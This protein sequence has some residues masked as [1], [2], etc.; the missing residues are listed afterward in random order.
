MTYRARNL[1]AA[2]GLAVLAALLVGFYVTNYKRSV[3]H[4]QQHVSVWVASKDIPEGTSG[5]DVISGGYL[6]QE[7]VLRQSVVPGAISSDTQIERLVA[8][9]P[10]YAGEQVSLTRFSDVAV[11]GIRGVLR[12]PLRAVQVSGDN[13]QTL[14]GTLRTGDHIDIVANVKVGDSS[15][16]TSIS[17][18]V[19]R[20]L[21]VLR[22]AGDVSQGVH[23]SSPSQ[24]GASVL[25]AVTDTQVQKL[26][27]V[28]KNDDWTFELRPV[29]KATDSPETVETQNTIV[30]DGLSSRQLRIAHGG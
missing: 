27:Y 3:Q 11:Q 30:D 10:T 22:A 14:A 12:G 24:G 25:L 6:R 15:N 28:I 29:V 8:A 5:T 18:I 13:D 20:N 9:Q 16:G 7:Q 26:F 19:L 1:F 17:R 23:L 4:S 21:R 2:I